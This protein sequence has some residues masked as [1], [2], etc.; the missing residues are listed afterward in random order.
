MRHPAPR[1]PNC[2]QC[3]RAP[4]RRLQVLRRVIL[5][6]QFN[7][8][9][10]LRRL[11]SGRR[12]RRQR[13]WDTP[14]TSW[15]SRRYTRRPSITSATSCFIARG[16]NGRSITDRTQHRQELTR[17]PLSVYA[18]FVSRSSQSDFC[19]P[20]CYSDAQT[21]TAYAPRSKYSI[22]YGV[23]PG[24]IK[25]ALNPRRLLVGALGALVVNIR[26]GC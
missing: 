5:G 10:M 19:V 21:A 9:A 7:L 2:G 18:T 4:A 25:L 12:R 3:E 15:G 14:R 1:I 6:K 8:S 11:L 24:A 20:L 23:R 17:P 13:L 26:S 16:R 22:R